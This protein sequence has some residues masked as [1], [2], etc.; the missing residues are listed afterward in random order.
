MPEAN[1]AIEHRSARKRWSAVT[2]LVGSTGCLVVAGTSCS[3]VSLS[4]ST[5]GAAASQPLKSQ[6]VSYSRAAS[7]VTSGQRLAHR[8]RRV[9]NGRRQNRSPLVIRLG[10]PAS[11]ESTDG[12]ETARQRLKR[13]LP[14]GDALDRRI[15]GIA[16]PSV[17][18]LLIFPLV[19]AVDT[20]WVGQM[21]DPLALAGQGAAN[22]IFSSVFWVI[23][24]LPSVTTPLVAKAAASGDTEEA[25][26]RVCEATFLAVLMGSVGA[27]LL[28]L[29]TPFVLRLV[30]PIGAPAR[31]F[32]EPY[33]RIRALSFIPALIATVGFASFRGILDTVTP[34]RVSFVS[35]LL[36][37]CM[38]PILMFKFKMGMPGAA[39]ATVISEL[40]SG[41]A[42]VVLLARRQLMTRASLFQVPSLKRLMPLL[43]G[44][45]A[46]QLRALAMNA[47]FIFATAEAQQ[48]D[49]TGV[50]AAAY[51]IS[52]Q[53]WQ[54]SG[55]ILYALQGCASILV[56]SE[57]FRKDG[58]GWLASRNVADRLLLLGAMLG[59]VVGCV[60][61]LA[62][63]LLQAFSPL[64]AVRQA[65][66]GPVAIAS[67]MSI[68]SGVVFAGEG[69]MMGRGA[70]G[71][72]ALQTALA[73]TT[74]MA[75]IHF[76]SRLGLG[77]VGVWMSIIAFN[78]VNLAGVLWHHLWARRKCPD[79]ESQA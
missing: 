48:M 75:G 38:D 46:V 76:T 15:V 28:G 26:R 69:I 61:I 54:L 14:R 57:L 9:A 5:S 35:N 77:L 63:P 30:L 6:W 70:W 39:G 23:A 1:S 22:Q 19:N 17:A 45:A 73:S 29:F 49:A 31:A 42:Y 10:E 13:G 72:L 18:N 56:P 58:G 47:A 40:C 44:G 2:V 16:L 27:V 36:N 67:I 65:A 59:V 25:R 68:F 20:F 79:E 41:M 74:M 52:L 4:S 66:V 78:V 37:V 43:K 32:A 71:A 53:F 21:G 55:V 3:F 60:Q 24:F 51:A 50:S 12:G 33:L 34:L 11:A 7:P 64:P 8:G 62:L